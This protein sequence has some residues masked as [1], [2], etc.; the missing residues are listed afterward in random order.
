MIR[1]P[2]PATN[3]LPTIKS[4]DEPVHEFIST[5]SDL[6]RHASSV[7]KLSRPALVR[8]LGRM[9]DRRAAAESLVREMDVISRRIEHIR[10]TLVAVPSKSEATNVRRI[11]A[12]ANMRKMARAQALLDSTTFVA[13]LGWT[14]QALSKALKARRVFFVEVDGSRRYPA[15]FADSRHERRHLE[16]VSKLLGDLPGAAKLQFFLTPKGSL[17]GV[18]PLDALSNGDYSSVRA[19]AEGF[20][21][22]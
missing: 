10:R 13:Q 17:G 2:M 6:A 3:R 9:P 1:L 18:S 22:R 12:S 8:Q 11:P 19:T 5:L 4:A 21:Q 16:A 15:F 20:T 7:E 14:R